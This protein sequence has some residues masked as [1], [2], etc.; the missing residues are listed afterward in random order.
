MIT[1]EEFL[2]TIDFHKNVEIAFNKCKENFDASHVSKNDENPYLFVGGDLSGIQ[3]FIYNIASQKAAVSLK[4]RSFYLQLLIDSVIQCI[5]LHP[6]INVVKE[7]IIYSSGGKFYMLLPNIKT[8]TDALNDLQEEF[9]KKLWETHF[10]QLILSIDYINFGDHD[11]TNVSDLWKRLADKLTQKKNKKFSSVIEREFDNLFAPQNVNGKEQVCVVTGIESNC[12]EKL[13]LTDED[14]PFVLPTVKEQTKLGN[15]LKDTEYI[16]ALPSEL[17]DINKDNH[18]EILGIHNYLLTKKEYQKLN[19]LNI[20]Q[21]ITIKRLNHPFNPIISDPNVVYE[22]KFYGGNK[23]AE[24]DKNSLKTFDDLA[25]DS[26]FGILRMDVDGLGKIFIEGIQDKNLANYAKLSALL[27]YFFCGYLNEIRE[28][29]KNDVNIIYSGG[30]DVFAVGRWDKLIAFA[31]DIKTEFA[32]YI[33]KPE[34]SDL[35]SESHKKVTISGGIA[36]VNCKYPIAKSAQMAGEAEEKA[37]QFNNGTKNAITLFGEPISW[38]SEFDKVENIKK[39]FIELYKDSNMPTAILHKIISFSEMKD[40]G[41][42]SYVW[43]TAY[44]L[45][46]S[47]DRYSDANPIYTLCKNLTTELF[48][49]KRNYKLYALAARW[50]ELEIREFIKY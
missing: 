47:M 2:M 27:D 6:N 44:Y 16:L 37:K 9:E 43:N 39:E 41:D 26:Y 5:L 23:Q 49:G 14:S 11:I 42:I 10:G 29:Y 28:K 1:I 22:C 15:A 12:C 38:E 8:V 46:R 48:S 35:L 36:I 45:K 33:L 25:D 30:D 34:F 7:H 21:K 17:S 24:K 50:A 13:N 31:E 18:I 32:T 3:K 19:L 4:G 20:P 40:R